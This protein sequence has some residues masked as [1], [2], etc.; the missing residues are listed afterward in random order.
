MQLPVSL[1]ESSRLFIRAYTTDDA[2]ALFRLISAE[3]ESLKNYFPLTV[4]STTSLAATRTFIKTRIKETKEGKSTFYGIFEKKTGMLIGQIAVREINWRVPKCELGYF[5]ISEKR[6][7]G[8]APEALDAIAAFCFEK[9][10]MVKLLLRIENINL[11]SKRVAEKCGFSCSGTLRN[12]FRSSD[13]RLMDCEVWE[14][15]AGE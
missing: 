14:K 3:K 15:I 8:F 10:G 1:I 2:A 5:I 4:E 7:Q 13:G 12:D 9:A 11:S 6:G